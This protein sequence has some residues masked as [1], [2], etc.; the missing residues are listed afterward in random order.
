MNSIAL[1]LICFLILNIRLAAYWSYPSTLLILSSGYVLITDDHQIPTGIIFYGLRSFNNLYT[2]S[3][4]ISIMPSNEHL[5]MC[6]PGLGKAF[7]RLIALKD[8]FLNVSF[9][10]FLCSSVETCFCAASEG[11]CTHQPTWN[12]DANAFLTTTGLTFMQRHPKDMLF[13]KLIPLYHDRGILSLARGQMHASLRAPRR[14]G[15]KEDTRVHQCGTSGL[16]TPPQSLGTAK[17]GSGSWTGWPSPCWLLIL[18]EEWV[19]Y[20]R[21]KK[22]I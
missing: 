3:S 13:L 4:H 20:S 1:L 16:L 10:S 12:R 14:G 21:K 17:V 15:V 2:M 22:S 11:C 18:N 5:L 19:C 9:F 7:P 8:S 6:D